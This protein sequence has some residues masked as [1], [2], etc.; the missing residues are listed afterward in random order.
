MKDLFQAQAITIIGGADGPTSIY[1]SSG[2]IWQ[3]ILLCVVFIL[4]I[5]FGV[6]RLIK[7]IKKRKTVRI[8][9]WTLIL[10]LLFF[11][12]VC[13]PVM[14]HMTKMTKYDEYFSFTIDDEYEGFP[15][16]AEDF[17]YFYTHNKII[18]IHIGF[19]GTGFGLGRDLGNNQ[20]KGIKE[21][22]G[23]GV[24][25]IAEDSFI[26]T[27]EGNKLKF[28]TEDN[29]YFLLENHVLRYFNQNKEYRIYDIVDDEIEYSKQEGSANLQ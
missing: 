6:Y 18:N 12:G 21:I 22:Y 3:L 27:I 11:L 14:N 16:E 1:V 8:V 25:V 9:I 15:T 29:E 19:A 20:I 26:G 17:Y 4:F 7:N 24:S 28:D 13:I 23:S 5:V 10:F 2:A